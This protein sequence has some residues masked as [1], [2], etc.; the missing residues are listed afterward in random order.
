MLFALFGVL[1]LYAA[2]TQQDKLK[3]L[4]AK[5]AAAKNGTATTTTPAST[6]TGPA[7]ASDSPQQ[8]TKKPAVP[9]KDY[10]YPVSEIV[11]QTLDQVGKQ[12][13]VELRDPANIKT[14]V[15]YD[16]ATGT[17]QVVTKLG[18]EI[19]STPISLTQEEYLKFQEQ[20]SS[21]AYWRSKNKIDYSKKKDEFSLTDMQFD[22]GLGDKIFGEGGV[23]LKTQGSVETKFGLKTNIVDNP[24][25]ST[26][27]RN[28]TRFNFDQNI[29][30]SVNGKVGDKIDVNMNY[31]TEATFQY[32]AKSIKLRYDGKEDEIIKSLEAGNVSMP[33]N[34]SLITGGSTLF[35]VKSELQFGKLNLAGVISQQQSQTK[36]VSLSGGVQTSAFEVKADEYDENRHYFLSQYFRN[37]YDSWMSQMPFISSGIAIKKVEVWVTNKSSVLDNARNIVAFADMGEPST[38]FNNHWTAAG[39]P[40]P[41]NASNSLYNEIITQ[42]NDAR[43]F[44]QA[45]ATL[46]PLAL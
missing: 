32:D 24:S 8:S 12:T 44:S 9:L 19:I 26:N 22:I 35:G 15:E 17:Y 14:V 27:A 25:L 43:S 42:F 1:S 39:Q 45:N 34:S 21:A 30:M 2:S 3:E 46:A 13:A 29:Q 11:P 40:I 7:K 31:D 5:R 20:Q 33:I 4:L 6:A 41:S 18:D 28:R 36:S 23:R 38:I 37:N 10:K 16:P